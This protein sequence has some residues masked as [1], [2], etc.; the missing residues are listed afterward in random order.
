MGLIQMKNEL[1]TKKIEKIIQSYDS[2][3]FQK[4]Q[5][6]INELKKII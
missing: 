4:S 2:G 6:I 1:F 3:K 5:D